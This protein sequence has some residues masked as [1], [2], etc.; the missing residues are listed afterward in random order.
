MRLE[1]GR[2]LR[3]TEIFVFVSKDKEG[4]EGIMGAMLSNGTMMPLI[5]ADSERLQ[6][7]IPVANKIKEMT[8]MNY[9]IRYFEVKR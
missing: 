3:I 5:G 8:G 6:S 1:N 2:F 7:L 4:H 9:E